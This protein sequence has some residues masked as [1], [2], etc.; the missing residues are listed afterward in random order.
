VLFHGRS[1]T[2]KRKERNRGKFE[3]EAS[4]VGK[5]TVILKARNRG[6]R[7][8]KGQGGKRNFAPLSNRRKREYRGGGEVTSIIDRRKEIGTGT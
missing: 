3:A 8:L 1:L 7:R 6:E 2:Q 5:N 4:E